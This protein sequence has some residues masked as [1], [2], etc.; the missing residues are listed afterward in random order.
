MN[1]DCDPTN[2]KAKIEADRSSSDV[3]GKELIENSA[4][5]DNICYEHSPYMNYESQW[6]PVT[7]SSLASASLNSGESI[8][9]AFQEYS[10]K[11]DSSSPAG[12][13]QVIE[14]EGQSSN[15]IEEEA[16]SFHGEFEGSEFIKQHV[17]TL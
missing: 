1:M 9:P 14:W 17:S 10:I 6:L 8:T 5:E 15:A 2:L 16:T 7:F 13:S 12:G 11:L 3:T 4:G